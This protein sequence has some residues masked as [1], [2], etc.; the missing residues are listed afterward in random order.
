MMKAKLHLGNSRNLK[1]EIKQE[2]SDAVLRLYALV[3]EAEEERTE[4][5]RTGHGKE[6]EERRKEETPFSAPHQPKADE[7]LR[8]MDEH[9][10]LLTE[11]KIEMERLTEALRKQ[12]E[13]SENRS[14]YASV[15]AGSP[16]R[17]LPEATAMHSIIVA[18]TDEQETGEQV[19]ERIRKVINAKEEGARI[20]RIRKVKDRKII[21]SCR[22]EEELKRV[23]RKIEEE[24]GQLSAE[25][26]KNK[27]PLIILYGVLNCNTDEDIVRAIRVQ[28]K[29]ILRDV[30]GEDDRI[31][32]KYRRKARNPLTSHVVVKVSPR[33]WQCVTAAGAVHVD[34]QRIRAADQ[35][36][37]MQCSRCLGYGHGK[38]FCAEAVDVCSHCGGAH[39]KTECPDFLTDTP[40]SCIN[41]HKAKMNRTDHNAFSNDCPVRRK[42]DIIARS[43][44]A[45]C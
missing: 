30:N 23:K 11:N 3:K 17:Q 8:K 22:S 7:I 39:L 43:T 18:S 6:K 2:V 25:N 10:K 38:R 35:S 44:V 36:P 1:T 15:A 42:W 31:E 27:D 9:S 40:P 37:L 28:N 5:N 12:Q 14:T 29:N 21:V 24:E 32:I 33:I 4:T 13:W 34:M 20:D 19:Y 41:C 26:I 45:Y 16:R